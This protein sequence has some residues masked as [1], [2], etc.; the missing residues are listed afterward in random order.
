MTCI[1]RWLIF[2]SDDKFDLQNKVGD[3]VVLTG[4][5]SYNQPTTSATTFHNIYSSCLLLT[6]ALKLGNQNHLKATK[7]GIILSTNMQIN[8]S[9]GFPTV[10]PDLTTGSGKRAE[11]SHLHHGIR[12][13]FEESGGTA[14]V[15]G[16][17]GIRG[18]PIVELLVRV[19]EALVVYQIRV[20][21][22]IKSC[23]AL[24]VKWGEVVVAAGAGTVGLQ[25]W[26]EG[27]IDVSFT[28]Y[29]SSKG[30]APRLPNSVSA[31]GKWSNILL[32]SPFL[33]WRI[34]AIRAFIKSGKSYTWESHHFISS[35]TFVWEG[36]D[37]SAE[38]HSGGRDVAVSCA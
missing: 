21:R 20:V 7:T 5:L 31:W 29:P 2:T 13:V 16:H 30:C 35:E 12:K 17:L 15:F 18:T 6:G 23:R 25:R 22:V 4:A 34:I 8:W 24:G 3:W 38:V 9:V 1:S 11:V 10:G 19:E 36:S 28:V 32:F 26:L 37:E 33:I 27:G 14:L